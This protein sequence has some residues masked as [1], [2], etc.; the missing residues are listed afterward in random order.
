MRDLFAETIGP[1]FERS[2]PDFLSHARTVAARLWKER[3]GPITINDVRAAGVHPPQHIDPR[4]MGAVFR[5][6]AWECVGY[7]GSV[8]RT[9]H[10]RPVAM[11]VRRED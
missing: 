3:D 11:F 5:G 10:G 2:R 1:S 6:D 8:R 4:V 9:S 7:I